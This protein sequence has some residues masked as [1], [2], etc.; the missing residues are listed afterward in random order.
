MFKAGISPIINFNKTT[1]VI[2]P[3]LDVGVGW[4]F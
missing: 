3:W 2:I 1:N 4:G